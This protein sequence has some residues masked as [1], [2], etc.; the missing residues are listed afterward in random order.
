[1]ANCQVCTA[2]TQM[3]L[4]N[5]HTAELA[6]MLNGLVKG[7]RHPNG[8]R[9]PGWL[10]LL[11]DATTG[12][13]RMGDGRRTN[14]LPALHGDEPIPEGDAKLLDRFLA[15]G[16]INAR[17]ARIAESVNAKLVAL[18]RHLEETRGVVF[19]PLR[20]VGHRFIGPL[21]PNWRRLPK[22]YIPTGVDMAEWL[23][24]HTRMLALD[25]AAKGHYSDVK[26]I[27][28]DIE[29]VINRPPDRYTCGP[30]PTV[31]DT[32]TGRR[33]CNLQL[34]AADPDAT[35]TCPR[36]KAEHRAR[37][38][39]QSLLLRARY[40]PMTRPLLLRAL[41]ELGEPLPKQTFSRWTLP[42]EAGVVRLHP[43]GSDPHTGEP[44]Y[45]LDDVRK[46]PRRAYDTT[47]RARKMTS[48]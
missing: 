2:K 25:E 18:V 29:R 36:C 9:S 16:G 43:C 5:N 31:I 39:R 38:L 44:T 11:H 15:A 6:Y 8:T 26:G 4:C 30:C 42:N 23:H 41:D 28:E 13:T 10:E 19:V 12:H 32:A 14:P 34:Y 27:V 7:I 46:I 3:F 21:L 1:M 37:N 35:I 33:P 45:W 48:V 22:G 47:Q 17:A 20:T 24:A 40:L